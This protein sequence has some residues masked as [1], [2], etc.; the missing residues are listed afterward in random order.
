VMLL[1]LFKPDS[2]GIANAAKNPMIATTTSISK[3]VNPKRGV[4]PRLPCH[5]PKPARGH[6]RVLPPP[7]PPIRVGMALAPLGRFPIKFHLCAV[8]PPKK[9][10]TAQTADRSPSRFR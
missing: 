4:P 5:V 3:T 1:D 8:R 6:P 2:A 7:R 10:G 9:T